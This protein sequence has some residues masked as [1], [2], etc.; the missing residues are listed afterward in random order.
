MKSDK[1]EA[2][3]FNMDENHSINYLYTYIYKNI[4]TTYMT[5]KVISRI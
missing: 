1:W 2:L 3:K 5:K 4:H